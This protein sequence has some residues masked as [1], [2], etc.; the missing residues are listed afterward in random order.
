MRIPKYAMVG[1]DLT[2]PEYNRVNE[3]GPGWPTLA[4]MSGGLNLVQKHDFRQAQ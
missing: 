4:G 3:L 2:P 1:A